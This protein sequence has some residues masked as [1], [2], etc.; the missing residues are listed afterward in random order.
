[1][2]LGIRVREGIA[3]GSITLAFR[4]WRRPSVRAGTRLRTPSGVVAIDSVEVISPEEVTDA[5][6][7]RAGFD[8]APQVLA[9]LAHRAEYPLY[10]IE[11]H[12]GGP[13][14]RVALR[15]RAKLSA[16]DRAE[17]DAPLARMDARSPTGPWTRAVLELIAARPEVLAADLAASR[18]EEKQPFKRRVRRLKEL[19]L[20]ESLRVGYRLSPRGEAYLGRRE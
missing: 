8:S 18:G 4:R 17:I 7:R 5:D 19:G 20:T 6:A 10:R 16:E 12:F 1:V 2:L 13:D 11:L 14:P 9:A 15:R 3:A